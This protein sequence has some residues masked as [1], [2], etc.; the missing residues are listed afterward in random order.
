MVTTRKSI[1]AAIGPE[2]ANPPGLRHCCAATCILSE[3][4][5]ACARLLP[6]AA[7]DQAQR[8]LTFPDGIRG[9]LQ[10]QRDI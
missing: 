3:Q 8:S 7:F 5:E 2:Q 9:G 1:Q 4:K 6:A 10:R